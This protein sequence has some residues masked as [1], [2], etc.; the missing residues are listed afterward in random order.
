VARKVVQLAGLWV[1][2]CSV[3]VAADFWEEKPFMSWSDKDA[4]KMLRDSPWADEVAVALPPR[5]PVPQEV[6]ATGGR[7]GGRGGGDG[8]GAD[9]RR[10]VMQVSW[11][12]ALPVRQA[13]VRAQT[14]E[15]GEVSEGNQEFLELETPYYVVGVLGVPP[16]FGRTP[17]EQIKTESFLQRKDKPPIPADD[18]TFQQGQS[19]LLMLVAFPRSAGVTVEDKDVEFV[20]KLGDFGIKK[21]FKLKD[22]VFQ[23]KLEM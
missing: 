11:R 15:G 20:T 22:M 6:G 7:G 13:L 17:L 5:L 18:V 10:I 19:G 3:L 8:F 12:S 9:P 14:G 21:K 23:G 16:Q 1:L 2:A 4:A